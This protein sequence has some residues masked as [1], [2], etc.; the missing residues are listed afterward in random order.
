MTTIDDL[1]P[2]VPA[3]LGCIGGHGGFRRRL[4][5]MGFLPGT[6]VRVVR[7]VEVGGLV[8]VEVRGCRISLRSAEAHR[9]SVDLS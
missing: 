2:G 6:P 9:I 8:E 7:R 3:R 1:G 4:L 5:E